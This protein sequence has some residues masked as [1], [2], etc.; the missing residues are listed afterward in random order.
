MIYNQRN[1]PFSIMSDLVLSTDRCPDSIFSPVWNQKKDILYVCM[2]PSFKANETL[3][4]HAIP[5]V[6][7]TARARR[8]TRQLTKGKFN[9]AFPFTNPD[10]KIMSLLR[11]C[12]PAPVFF[13]ARVIPYFHYQDNGNTSASEMLI[14]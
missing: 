1:M 7:R 5:D 11:S 2:G 4:I 14:E 8:Q 10:G 9:N 6:S 13:E 12:H 3:E